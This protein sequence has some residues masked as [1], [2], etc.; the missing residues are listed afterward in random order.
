MLGFVCKRLFF[1]CLVCLGIILFVMLG[2]R[3]AANSRGEGRQYALTSDLRY[4]ISATRQYVRG[5]LRGDWGTIRVQRGRNVSSLPVGALLA[6]AYPK[7]L[8]LLAIALLFS[9]SIGVPLGVA[10]ALQRHSGWSL[11]VLSLTLVG[12]SLPTFLIAAL[13]QTLEILWYRATGTRLF[14]VGGY[15]WDLRLVVPTLVLG[16][17]PL[18]MLMR[19]SYMSFTDA[20]EQDYVNTARAKGLSRRAITWSHVYP[21]AAMPILTALC[22]SLRFALGSLPVVEY[23][24]GWPG[25]GVRLLETIRAGQT[26]GVAGLALALGLTI[27]GINLVLDIAYRLMDPRLREQGPSGWSSP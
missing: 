23:L 7:S 2:M 25:L 18:A 27:M 14:A 19:V 15:G 11:G 16:A 1:I 10:A 4:G 6:S 22:V 8:G 20:L 13:L 24:V 17:R 5:L 12:I 3:M 21:N 26:Q 9:A